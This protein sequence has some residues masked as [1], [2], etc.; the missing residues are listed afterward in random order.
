MKTLNWNSLKYR[1][2]RLEEIIRFREH[3]NKLQLF[4]SFEWN[5]IL[6]VDYLKQRERSHTTTTKEI[7]FIFKSFHFH[8]LTLLIFVLTRIQWFA[9]HNWNK[10]IV[11]SCW[12]IQHGFGLFVINNTFCLQSRLQCI[13]TF[14][15]DILNGL[16]YT[17]A[18][19]FG[20]T[21][22]WIYGRLYWNNVPL[23]ALLL[24][25]F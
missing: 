14:A 20:W 17:L 6:S 13:I 23:F 21:G 15:S 3:S 9:K 11:W 12:V 16:I 19:F 10:Q 22:H 4:I 2:C 7:N 8:H 1:R 18:F 24:G 5:V 25:S